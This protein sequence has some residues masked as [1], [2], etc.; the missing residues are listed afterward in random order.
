PN[1]VAISAMG[2]NSHSRAICM[3]VF[4]SNY[5][6]SVG[7]DTIIFAI[8]QHFCPYFYHYAH[9]YADGEKV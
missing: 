2:S 8:K 5:V 6:F 4:I 9:Q 1:C 3:S 7:K